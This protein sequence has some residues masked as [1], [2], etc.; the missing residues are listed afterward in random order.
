[1]RS[2][3][4]VLD[5]ERALVVSDNDANNRLFELVGRDELAERMARVGLVSSR[6]AHRLGDSSD[7]PPPAFE[8]LSANR[9]T[10]YVAQRTGFEPPEGVHDADALVGSAHVDETGRVIAGPMDF[11]GKNRVT[12]RE[13]QDLLVMMVRPDLASG[14]VPLLAKDDRAALLAILGTLPSQLHG[15]RFRR[16]ID[17]L[18]KALHLAIAA[19]VPDD[20]VR[21]LGKG[22]RALGFEIENSYAVDE[23]TGRSFFVS[24]VIYA[25]ETGTLNDDR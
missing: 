20:R 18:N 12:L 15:G 1:M 17:E 23:T 2:R 9:E 25:N 8:W 14:P 24:A 11:S 5:V 13:L 6:I 19:A 22:G 7:A 21:V 16:T 3:V 4:L 10:V